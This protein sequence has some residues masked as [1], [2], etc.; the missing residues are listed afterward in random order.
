MNNLTRH[1]FTMDI[2]LSYVTSFN[3]AFQIADGPDDLV[4]LVNTQEQRE[5]IDAHFLKYNT[6]IRFNSVRT[7]PPVLNTTHVNLLS[8]YAIAFNAC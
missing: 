7:L 1:N 3:N 4:S 6:L 5:L 2:K 8:L